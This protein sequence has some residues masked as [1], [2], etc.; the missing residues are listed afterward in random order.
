[1]EKWIGEDDEDYK[2]DGHWGSDD[3]DY[4]DDGHQDSDDEDI[5]LFNNIWAINF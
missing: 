5:S 4:K 2:V 3:R 1:M